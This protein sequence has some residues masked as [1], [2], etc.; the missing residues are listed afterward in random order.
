M[1]RNRHWLRQMN[2]RHLSRN[3]SVLALTIFLLALCVYIASPMINV[4]SDSEFALHVATSIYS[5]RY[6]ELSHWAPVLKHDPMVKIMGTDW[7]RQVV[8]TDRGIYSKYPIGAPLMALPLLVADDAVKRDA[9]GKLETRTIPKVEQRIAA[10]LAAA[11]IAVLYLAMRRREASLTAALLATLAFALGTSMWSTASRALWQH[12]PLML[13]FAAAIFF[14]SRNP[15]RPV[16]AAAAGLALGYAVVIRQTAG[17]ALITIG[18]ALLWTNWRYAF[19]LAASAVAPMLILVAYDLRS[20]D[21][22]GNPYTSM[23]LFSWAWSWVAFAGLMIAP[24]RGLLV[25]SPFLIFA[26]YGFVHLVRRGRA[27]ALDL[28]YGAYVMLLWMFMACWPAWSGGHSYGPR[29]MSDA[30]PFLM[31]YVAIAWDALAT[32]RERTAA[33]AMA[34]VLL[35]LAVSCFIHGRGAFDGD[36]YVWN[37]L[38]DL[39]ARI[40]SVQDPQFLYRLWN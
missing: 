7:P 14:L 25:F 4:N 22:I 12:G 40:W 2:L 30:L 13:C 37:A 26:V 10:I 6:G 39:E 35:L 19:A 8:A 21:S 31:L 28:A 29:M 11:G 16:D 3:D 23:F 36:V 20:F 24:S 15:L 1:N 5:G 27:T 33:A 32:R 34:A 9:F 18:L 38:P 17:I